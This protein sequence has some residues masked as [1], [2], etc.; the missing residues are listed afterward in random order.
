MSFEFGLRLAC[1]SLICCV[2]CIMT[3]WPSSHYTYLY[4]HLSCSSQ[5]LSCSSQLHFS[6]AA[7][8]RVPPSIRHYFWLPLS[9]QLIPISLSICILPSWNNNISLIHHQ[10]INEN[11]TTLFSIHL[12]LHVTRRK[13]SLQDRTHWP[14]SPSTPQLF[15]LK[16]ISVPKDGCFRCFH[17]NL[18]RTIV[19][20]V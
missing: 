3:Y 8:H 11:I 14:V 13:H 10:I 5:L 4:Q 17:F 18:S 6:T 19:V 20:H 12:P 16:F 7:P 2:P 9:T 1:A 15:F